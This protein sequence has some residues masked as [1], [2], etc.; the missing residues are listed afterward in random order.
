[1]A[2]GAAESEAEVEAVEAAE[3]WQRRPSRKRGDAGGSSYSVSWPIRYADAFVVIHT[4]Y[5]KVVQLVSVMTSYVPSTSHWWDNTHSP[6]HTLTPLTA[7]SSR[8]RVCRGRPG[9]WRTPETG[10]SQWRR[11]H[12]RGG[13]TGQV[14]QLNGRHQDDNPNNNAGFSVCFHC[15]AP[16]ILCPDSGVPSLQVYV[17]QVSMGF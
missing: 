2:G 5:R 16:L 4:R 10:A 3:V 17:Y 12:P 14:D 13:P 15:S 9:E 1:M 6:G 11:P 7:F 8:P